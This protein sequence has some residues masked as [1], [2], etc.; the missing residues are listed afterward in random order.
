MDLSKSRG[1]LEQLFHVK[2]HLSIIFESTNPFVVQEACYASFC[3]F[4]FACK[5]CHSSNMTG[6]YKLYV[7]GDWRKFLF[8]LR[9]LARDS[10]V[11]YL[12][13]ADLLSYLVFY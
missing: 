4:F 5:C 9:P 3:R 1:E 7:C 13:F 11:S 12:C 8:T 10:A 6:N 2:E